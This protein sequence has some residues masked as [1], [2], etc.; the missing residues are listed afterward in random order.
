MSVFYQPQTL[1]H[2]I[3][4]LTKSNHI[5]V[6]GVKDIDNTTVRVESLTARFALEDEPSIVLRKCSLTP[7]LHALYYLLTHTCQWNPIDIHELR[8]STMP[9][10]TLHYLIQ[11][12]GGLEQMEMKDVEQINETI[13]GVGEFSF[14]PSTYYSSI[15][16]DQC[17]IPSHTLNLLIQQ[18]C[19]WNQ[20]YMKDVEQIDERVTRVGEFSA[21]ST[22]D[23]SIKL[24]HCTIPLHTLNRLMQGVNKYSKIKRLYLPHTTLTGCLSSLLSDPHPDLPALEELNLRNTGLN[25]DDLQYLAHSTHSKQLP[26]LQILDLSENA[27][28]GCLSSFLPDHHPGLSQLEK[29]N[30]RSAS[31]NKDGLQHLFSF[32][33]SNKL[34]NLRELDLSRNTLTGCLSSFLPDPH[35]G[36][37]ELEKLNLRDTGLNKDDLQHL[38][39]ITQ[40][41]KLPK[42]QVLDLSQ[43]TLTGCL[44]TLLPDSHPGLPELEELYLQSNILN[45]D[46]LQNLSNITQSNKLRKLRILDL[47]QNTL[48]G[49]MSS[50]LIDPHPGLPELEEL[51]LRETSLNKEDL[52]H[53]L[54]IME[55]RKLPKLR[56]LTATTGCLSSDL[57]DP[58]AGEVWIGL[59]NYTL[60]L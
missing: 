32:R 6:D 24:D 12:V 43:N 13:V 42:L 33:Q 53:L 8:Y 40:S 28:S 57:H 10:E 51:Y 35:P 31:L 29:L 37:P 56:H 5:L 14:R 26:N 47:S 58:H 25:K 3:Q 19:G 41:S 21:L 17:T 48:A 38:S 9:I 45:K 54:H 34:P 44:L 23:G 46:D 59:D 49:T 18:I 15:K 52:Q 39:H 7:E 50:F 2:L 16:L 1:N 60:Q 22:N 4:Q 55:C 11:Q 20:I 30:L 36:L 27:L